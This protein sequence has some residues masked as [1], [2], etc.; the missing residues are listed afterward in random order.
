MSIGSITGVNGSPPPNSSLDIK[1]TNC[2]SVVALSNPK[3]LFNVVFEIFG[4]ELTKSSTSETSL[5][6]ADKPLWLVIFSKVFNILPIFIKKL[7][8]QLQA[9]CHR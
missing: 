9:Y 7:F 5:I 3:S 1:E 8:L 6:P 2:E 4:N